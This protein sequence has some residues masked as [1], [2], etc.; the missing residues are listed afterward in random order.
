MKL[1]RYAPKST[2]PNSLQSLDVT[3]LTIPSGRGNVEPMKHTFLAGGNVNGTT[4]LES[5]LEVSYI[6]KITVVT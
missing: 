2:I 5:S 4:T 6:V 3:R 1:K